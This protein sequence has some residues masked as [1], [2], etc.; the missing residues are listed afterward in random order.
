MAL[1]LLGLVCCCRKRCPASL[2]RPGLHAWLR[3]AV[4]H[5]HAGCNTCA[6]LS[7]WGLFCFGQLPAS[8][9]LGGWRVCRLSNRHVARLLVRC[10]VVSL[11][12]YVCAF[13]ASDKPCGDMCCAVTE[14]MSCSNQQV[15]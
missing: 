6:V 9:G 12:A 8:Q 5:Y 3:M 4:H 14:N 10:A 13:G 7:F 11:D 1:P 2:L 15:C